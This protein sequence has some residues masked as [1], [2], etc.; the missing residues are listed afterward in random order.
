MPPGWILPV[1]LDFQVTVNG[2]IIISALIS[3]F[4]WLFADFQVYTE[5]RDEH[6]K[7]QIIHNLFTVQ[8]SPFLLSPL[9]DPVLQ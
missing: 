3:K 9:I 8:V 2:T 4:Y 5:D 6:R 1:W 7:E